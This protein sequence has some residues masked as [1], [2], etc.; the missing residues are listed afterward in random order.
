MSIGVNCFRSVG[1][2]WLHFSSSL[3]C[4]P[5]TKAW[6]LQQLLVYFANQKGSDVQNVML[7]GFTHGTGIVKGLYH[8]GHNGFCGITADLSV[9][10]LLRICLVGEVVGRNAGWLS[11][12]VSASLPYPLLAEAMATADRSIV[13]VVWRNLCCWER[14][15][16]LCFAFLLVP[17]YYGLSI[18]C[19]TCWIKYC[20]ILHLNYCGRESSSGKLSSTQLSWEVWSLQE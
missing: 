8:H 14:L 12:I 5:L 11:W 15:N 16:Q 2:S 3:E 20:V 9:S 13:A 1:F 4:F 10:L 18:I 17:A 6:Q 7:R 19:E